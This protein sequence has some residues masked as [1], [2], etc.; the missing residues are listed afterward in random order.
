MTS[1]GEQ[2]PV[3]GVKIIAAPHGPQIGVGPQI[4]FPASKADRARIEKEA[5]KASLVMRKASE[6]QIEILRHL[7]RSLPGGYVFSSARWLE[8]ILEATNGFGEADLKRLF[9]FNWSERETTPARLRN[10]MLH[11]L[12]Q[13]ASDQP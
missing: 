1:G 4:P 8:A 12:K 7:A 11:F 5:G 9:A 6:A 10:E 2:Q 13:R 3:L